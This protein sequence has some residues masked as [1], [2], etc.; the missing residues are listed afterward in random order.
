MA[1]IQGDS[2]FTCTEVAAGPG[3]CSLRVFGRTGIVVDSWRRSRDR[4]QM[5]WVLTGGK[6]VFLCAISKLASEY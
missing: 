6:V 4:V 3:L 5:N 2:R 1:V